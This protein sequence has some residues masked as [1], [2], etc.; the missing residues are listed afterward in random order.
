MFIAT[1]VQTV[2]AFPGLSLLM[3]FGFEQNVYRSRSFSLF[4]A[5]ECPL[6]TLRYLDLLFEPGGLQIPACCEGQRTAKI[7]RCPAQNKIVFRLI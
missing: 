2:R 6:L 4:S 1:L 3:C 5:L 7:A